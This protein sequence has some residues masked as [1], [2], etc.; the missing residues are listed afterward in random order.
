[1]VQD[2]NLMPARPYIQS[3]GLAYHYRRHWSFSSSYIHSPLL[4]T[5][6]NERKGV[7]SV[8]NMNSLLLLHN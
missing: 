7:G 8:F 1:M 2:V 5:T 3:A 6:K 4:F